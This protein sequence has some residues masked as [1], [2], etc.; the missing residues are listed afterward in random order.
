[1]ENFEILDWLTEFLQK[2]DDKL[3]AALLG[4]VGYLFGRWEKSR[5]PSLSKRAKGLLRRLKADTTHEVKGITVHRDRDMVNYWPFRVLDSDK[6][7]LGMNYELTGEYLEVIQAVEE[8]QEK[9]YLT[10]EHE[11]EGGVAVYRLKD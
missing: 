11:T 2:H 5:R 10:V 7:E 8:M 3:L 6:V 1:M 9:G 4:L